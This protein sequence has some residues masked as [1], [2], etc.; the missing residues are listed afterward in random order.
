MSKM[1]IVYM[2]LG[3][4]TGLFV[5][6][7]P[8]LRNLAKKT[9]SKVD[10]TILELSIKAVEFVDNHFLNKS[11]NAKG[12]LATAL[13]TENLKAQGKKVAEEVV[14]KTVEKA[15]AINELDKVQKDTE[16]IKK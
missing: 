16:D 6:L 13:V 11:G 2:V 4:L 3:A 8:L 9:E 12:K 10:D 5:A 14:E 1:E 7:I 15:W